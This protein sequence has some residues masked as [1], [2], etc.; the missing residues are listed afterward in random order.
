[1]Q[2]GSGLAQGAAE[3]QALLPIYQ[4]EAMQA[5]IDGIADFPKFQEWLIKYRAEN[6]PKIMPR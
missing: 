6:A 4:R 3:T 1:M 5:Q 2:M